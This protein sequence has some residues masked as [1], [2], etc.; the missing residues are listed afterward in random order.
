L[1]LPTLEVAMTGLGELA[2]VG[3]VLVTLPDKDAVLNTTVGEE[4]FDG[5]AVLDDAA[6]EGAGEVKGRLLELELAIAGVLEL[7]KLNEVAGVL[8][9]ENEVTLKLRLNAGL[10]VPTVVFGKMIA[11]G[12]GRDIVLFKISEEFVVFDPE[13]SRPE[14]WL[15]V[16]RALRPSPTIL[17]KDGT[18]SDVHSQYTY[19]SQDGSPAQQPG[20]KRLLLAESP[21][22][23]VKAVQLELPAHR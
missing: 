23:K 12:D 21:A 15:L 5:G 18:V 19:G 8:E 6:G 2:E 13:I 11:D 10:V 9:L 16:L 4:V 17:S 7:L 20:P 22:L 3:L 1:V 14:N